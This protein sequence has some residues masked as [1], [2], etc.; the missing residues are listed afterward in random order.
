[1]ALGGCY[2]YLNGPW[3]EKESPPLLYLEDPLSSVAQ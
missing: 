3:Q 2:K 1:M